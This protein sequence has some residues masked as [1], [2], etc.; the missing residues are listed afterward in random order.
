MAK[1]ISVGQV[2]WAFYESIETDNKEAMADYFET[3][4]IHYQNRG[5]RIKIFRE[6]DD[7]R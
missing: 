2:R 4:F 1:L 3:L 5:K 6:K 7:K